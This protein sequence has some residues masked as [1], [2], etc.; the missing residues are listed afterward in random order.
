LFVI[1]IHLVGG[2]KCKGLSAIQ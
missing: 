2:K 1:Q